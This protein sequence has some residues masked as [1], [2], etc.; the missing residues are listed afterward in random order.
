[1]LM[2]RSTTAKEQLIEKKKPSWMGQ[3]LSPEV[4]LSFHTLI[5]FIAHA[6]Y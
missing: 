1:M 4:I 2:L 5:A 3:I 6:Y